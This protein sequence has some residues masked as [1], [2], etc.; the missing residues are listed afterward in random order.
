MLSCVKI[1]LSVTQI[2][3]RTSSGSDEGTWELWFNVLKNR[4]NA[5]LY[6]VRERKWKIYSRPEVLYWIK[7]FI[8]EIGQRSS[9]FNG[10][11][12]YFNRC[13]G[14][15]RLNQFGLMVL[16]IWNTQVSTH[17]VSLGHSVQNG[18]VLKK[19][20][21]RSVLIAGSKGAS[22]AR[23]YFW[24]PITFIFMKFS[25]T[26]WPN[27]RFAP[28]PWVGAPPS[29]KSWICHWMLQGGARRQGM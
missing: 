22:W 9:T 26:I 2:I 18:Y 1:N 24:G 11:C 25:G 13:P 14:V 15:Q 27:N 6:G 19:L 10:F 12:F 28:P 20:S 21:Q 16:D 29:G 23:A 8:L 17:I 3:P 4:Y 7:F 5:K